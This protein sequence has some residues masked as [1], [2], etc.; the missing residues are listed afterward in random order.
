MGFEGVPAMAKE[1]RNS[2]RNV[3]YSLIIVLV[4]TVCLYVGISTVMVGLVS[5]RDLNRG[6]PLS[7]AM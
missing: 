7:E 1:A 2:S 5:Y 6:N 4:I 3:F